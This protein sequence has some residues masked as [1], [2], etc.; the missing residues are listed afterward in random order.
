MARRSY[1]VVQAILDMLVIS[2]MNT[3]RESL[4]TRTRSPRLLVPLETQIHYNAPQAT[5]L[6]TSPVTVTSDRLKPTLSLIL[7]GS[8]QKIKTVL[9]STLNPTTIYD[10]KKE[11]H[12]PDLYAA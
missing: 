2:S 12:L 1:A 3:D 4:T 9:R 5:A 8:D 11:T 10:V 7:H 6:P